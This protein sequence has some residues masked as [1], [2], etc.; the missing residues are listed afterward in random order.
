M[1]VS[2]KHIHSKFAHTGKR[3]DPDDRNTKSVRTFRSGKPVPWIGF[4]LG[5]LLLV[6]GLAAL[7][8]FSQTVNIVSPIVQKPGETPTPTPDPLAPK[9]FLIMG[10]GGGKHEGGRLTDTIIVVR[11]IPKLKKAVLITIPRDLWVS[12]PITDSGLTPYKINAAF[13]IGSD[14][15]NYPNKPSE[16]T[17][18]HS[19]GKMAKFVLGEVLGMPIDYYVAIS[20]AG[21]K[22]A[23][24]TLGDLEIDVPYTFTDAYYPVE[25]KE[26]ESCDR[27][28]EDISQLTA[29]M[30]GFELEKQFGCRF[31]SI[32]F[33]R[34]KQ[35]M[36]ADTALKFVR[37]RHSGTDGGDFGRSQRQAALIKAFRNKV[38]SVDAVPKLIP[39]L[40]DVSEIVETDITAGDMARFI[41]LYSDYS[42]YKV[43]TV[44]LTDQN[45]LGQSTG[46]AGQ[47]IL[48]PK[49]GDGNWQELRD[50]IQRGIDEIS[51]TSTPTAT[52]SGIRKST[53]QLK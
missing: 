46:P 10:Y 26:T 23:I 44:S 52:P 1:S 33:T 39:L 32:T 3:V 16:Y 19:G 25:G 18:T 11:L 38:L 17:G 48:I 5:A 53:I 22:K 21:F 2:E 41:Q 14:D 36:D 13:A 6:S 30:S 31:E 9:N 20:F 7:F 37:S 43:I 4:I 45:V 8:F 50:F 27:T 29:T 49:A 47:Y 24:S 15:R 28:P 34:G 51:P 40:K 42:T 35:L 12:L